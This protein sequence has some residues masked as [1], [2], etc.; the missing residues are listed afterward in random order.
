MAILIS[1]DHHRA[2]P[3]RLVRRLC[4]S[5]VSR[6]NMEGRCVPP[7]PRE[8]CQTGPMRVRKRVCGSR[9]GRAE[10][11]GH[12]ISKPVKL[13]TAEPYL[14]TAPPVSTLDLDLTRR[15]PTERLYRRS[16]GIAGTCRAAESRTRGTGV[17]LLCCA[18]GH[19]S[20]LAGRSRP[21]RL[22]ARRPVHIWWLRRG[23]W[24]VVRTS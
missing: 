1:Q 23:T 17:S 2:S 10:A 12:M 4:A 20:R 14:D 18:T 5:Q 16:P 21:S 13:Q 7:D 3:A 22:T 6:L 24:Y 19:S 9:G 8:G 11:S 15:V